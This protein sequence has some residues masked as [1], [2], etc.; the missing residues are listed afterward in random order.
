[1]TT[2]VIPQC[3]GA[4]DSVAPE[5]DCYGK[6]ALSERPHFH[7][8]TEVKLTG[9]FVISRDHLRLSA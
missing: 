9:H 8:L 5:T 3:F 7:D 6:S 1:M 2:V 4:S